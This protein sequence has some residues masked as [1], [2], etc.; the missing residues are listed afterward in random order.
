MLPVSESLI[1]AWTFQEPIGTPKVAAGASGLVLRDGG[2]QPVERVEGGVFGPYAAR[3][4][5]ETWLH[6]PRA[7][8]GALN[9]HG[10]E[11]QVSVVAWVRR[12]RHPNPNACQA[13][14]GMWHETGRRRQ[15]CLF[16]NLRIWDSAEQVCGHVSNVGGPTPGYPYCMDASI[17]ATPVPFDVWQC[18]GFTYDG[19]YARSYLNGV[20]DVREGRNP[21]HYPG[22]L[23]DGGPDGA[24]FTVG[25]VHRSGEMG[26]H[27]I[28]DL[29]GLAIYDRALTDDEMS[30]LAEPQMST[31]QHG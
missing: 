25:Q 1:A 21:Y 14:A 29:G 8:C 4:G 26:N 15:Y 22:G 24:D 19:E 17:G 7:E 30:A 6:L 5:L 31:E 27:F 9:L 11:A 23:Y 3:F 2:E 18:V 16:L 10:P 20:L 12:G 28:G 13:V